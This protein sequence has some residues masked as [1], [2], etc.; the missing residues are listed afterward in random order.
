VQE[1]TGTTAVEKPLKPIVSGEADLL[2]G[3]EMD[4]APV[5]LGYVR[6]QTKPAPINCWESIGTPSSFAGRTDWG[7]LLY[8]LPTRNPAGPPTG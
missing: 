3:V 6:F 2:E 7:E 8:S 5:L 4:T 1:H